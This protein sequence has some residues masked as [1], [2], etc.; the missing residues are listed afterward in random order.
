MDKDTRYVLDNW[1]LI[2]PETRE[3][4]EVIG[5]HPNLKKSGLKAEEIG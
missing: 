3:M 2:P 1:G 5:I 4:L